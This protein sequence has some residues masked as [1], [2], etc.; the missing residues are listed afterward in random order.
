MAFYSDFAEYYEA[1]FPFE[2]DV[3]AFLVD[4]VPD[5]ASAVLDIGCG[6]GHFA[7]RFAAAGLKAAGV[8]LDPAMIDV[9][10]RSYPDADF[11]TMDM[12]DVGSLTAPFDLVFCIGN[13]AAH[14]EQTKLERFLTSVYGLVTPGGSWIVQTVNWDYI[15]GLDKFSFPDTH[16]ETGGT[17]GRCEGDVPEHDPVIV[18]SR[19]YE[20]ISEQR[21]HFLTKLTRDGATVFE[22]DVWLYPIRSADYVRIHERLGF[23]LLGHYAN[24]G[25]AE[26]APGRHSSSVFAFRRTE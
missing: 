16:V 6:T 5:R 10:R 12:L 3:H 18:F 24:F 2:E 9:A 21:L 22:G 13:V 15:L 14:L 4:H 8:D 23:E 20:E 11:Q 7:G 1:V 25:R 19:R 26:F 17:Q